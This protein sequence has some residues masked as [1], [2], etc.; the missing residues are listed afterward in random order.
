MAPDRPVVEDDWPTIAQFATRTEGDVAVSA[1][2]A[3]DVPSKLVVG[4]T[5][6]PG[7]Q[8]IDPNLDQATSGVQVRVAPEHVDEALAVL[9]GVD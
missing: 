3:A 5:E 7:P 4:H 9:S 8:G 1:L 2:T 6:P